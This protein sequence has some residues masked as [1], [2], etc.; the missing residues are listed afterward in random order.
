MEESKRRRIDSSLEV[1]TL[2]SG[3][4]ALTVS[5]QGLGC[6]GMTAFYG[7]P[8]PDEDA[9]A[10]LK[11]AA[12]NGVTHWDTAEAYQTKLEDGSIKWN[13]E[14]VA[15]GIAAVGRDSLTIATKYMPRMHGDT[16]T[17]EQALEACR[18]SNKRLGITCCDL[19]YV[20]RLAD[21]SPVEEQAKAMNAV[22]EAGLAK[23]IGVSEFSPKNIRAFHAICPITCVQQEWSLMNRDLEDELVPC[24]RELG[25]GI[26]AYSPLCRSLLAGHVKTV[27]D[28]GG[29]SDDL[30]P[31]R[32]GKLA[33]GN[34]EKNVELIE[35]VAKLAKEYDISTSQLS[36]AWVANQGSDVV[37]IPGTTKIAHLDEN[38]ASRSVVLSPEQLQL[39][40]SAVPQEKIVGDRYAGGPVAATFK[41]N[42]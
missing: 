24:C 20:H 19:Y 1:R 28:L 35:E 40:A 7:K 25:I 42:L 32:Y 18:A 17:A 34:L 38:L 31:S 12:A 36:L 14:V 29:G 26:V 3:K 23:F 6:M 9:V 8:V 2:G 33:A 4:H 37:P 30:R 16:L 15:K 22:V 27:A 13:E 11:H 39:I 21:K 41:A 10:L 5:A